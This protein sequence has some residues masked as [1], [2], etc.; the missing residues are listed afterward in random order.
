MT[1]AGPQ[2]SRSAAAS[3]PVRRP[4]AGAVPGGVLVT[5]AVSAIAGPFPKAPKALRH[6]LVRGQRQ[7]LGERVRQRY[8]GEQRDR[9]AVA[10]GVE[11]VARRLADLP[12]LLIDHALDHVPCHQRAVVED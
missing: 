4:P 12:E 10:G 8:L 3:A 5:A 1:S 7:E 2:M 9:L 11:A 6:A